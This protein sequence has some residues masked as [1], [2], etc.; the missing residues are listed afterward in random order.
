[1]PQSDFKKVFSIF[2]LIC[3]LLEKA[4]FGAGCFWGVE[5]LFRVLPG[6]TSTRV[7]YVGGHSARPTYEQVCSGE[8]GHAEAVEITYDSKKISY[9]TLLDVFWKNHNPITINQQGPDVGTQYRSVIFFHTPQQ[10]EMAERSKKQLEESGQ[11]KKPIVT[12]ILP[13]STFYEAEEYHQKYLAKQEKSSC[14]I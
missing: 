11:F 3:M 2:E 8:T 4:T 1:M 7:G 14:H 10:K 13:E 5:E 9:E 6:V 12:E